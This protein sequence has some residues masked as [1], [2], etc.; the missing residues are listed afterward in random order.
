M[1]V[2]RLVWP[3]NSTFRSRHRRLRSRR[4]RDPFEMLGSPFEADNP[5][6]RLHQPD[7]QE[8][9]LAALH[10]PSLLDLTS[11]EEFV[12][13]QLA[14]NADDWGVQRFAVGGDAA[15]WRGAPMLTFEP[16]PGLDEEQGRVDWG[17]G[18]EWLLGLPLVRVTLARLGG[19]IPERKR[20]AAHDVR[21]AHEA[22]ADFVISKDGALLKLRDEPGLREVNLLTPL[23]AGTVMGVWARATGR[24]GTFSHWSSADFLYYWALTRAIMPSA[25]PGFA[26]FVHGNR[27]FPNGRRLEALAQSI[28]TRLDYIVE[29]LDDLI[30]SWQRESSNPTIDEIRDLLDGIILR[31]SAIQ[32]NVALLVGTWFDIAMAYPAGWSIHD[33][34]WRR[35]VRGTGEQGRRV[36]DQMQASTRTLSATLVLRHHAVHRE[37][38]GALNYRS[39]DGTEQARV[40]LPADISSEMRSRLRSA[41]QRPDAWGLRDE[42]GPH[43][44]HHSIDHGGGLVDEFEEESA[45]GTFLE[46]M[47][48]GINLVASVARLAETVFAALDPAHDV[49]LPEP[50]RARSLRPTDEPWAQPEVGRQ[51]I[52]TGPLSGLVP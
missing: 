19:R 14:T 3:R 26:A 9:L 20:A 35:S 42:I 8:Q 38:L 37:A 30:L 1:H 4:E 10:V 44:V 6:D 48:F 52:L 32:D 18:T 34:K 17:G 23:E 2:R 29:A 16:I 27:V 39:E 24:G 13:G 31:G 25:W 45:G 50:L 47:A 36:I 28:L 33:P 46:P 40:F 21:A 49:R 15:G 43:R 51:L 12:V 11:D 22:G 41:R 5:F 7:H